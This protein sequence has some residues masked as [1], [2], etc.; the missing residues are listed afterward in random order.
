MNSPA[1]ITGL[2]RCLQLQHKELVQR[3]G[4]Q[5]GNLGAALSQVYLHMDEM[6]MLEEQRAQLKD[7]A[8]EEGDGR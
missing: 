4:Y 5:A 3:P 2:P 6:M 8:L 7:L 1:C